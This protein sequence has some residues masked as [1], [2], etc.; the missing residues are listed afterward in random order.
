MAVGASSFLMPWMRNIG[1]GQRKV[2]IY[3][4]TALLFDLLR[5]LAGFSSPS[6]F[7]SSAER[8]RG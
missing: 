3:R 5:R 2:T 7:E 1:Q 8:A 6:E 4:L